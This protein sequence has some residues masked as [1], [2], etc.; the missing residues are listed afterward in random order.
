M[1][2]IMSGQK[3]KYSKVFFVCVSE[4]M[5]DRGSSE[6]ILMA[7]ILHWE[8]KKGHPPPSSTGSD[9]ALPFHCLPNRH[10]KHQGYSIYWSLSLPSLSC[11]NGQILIGVQMWVCSAALPRKFPLCWLIKSVSLILSLPE[12]RANAGE[13]II[14]SRLENKKSGNGA[15]GRG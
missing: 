4:W 8:V 12:N 1:F 7:K 10:C 13:T 15:W 2:K 11:A 14:S 3:E 6:S 5:R 9:T